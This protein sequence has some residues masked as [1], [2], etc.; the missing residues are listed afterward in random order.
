MVVLAAIPGPGIMI[1]VSR[2]LSQGFTA[3]VVTSM[4]IV[5]GDFVFIVLVVYG[6]SAMSEFL[7]G[8]FLVV[9]YAG[10]T[11]LI[12]LGLKVLLTSNSTDSSTVKNNPKHATNF[13]AGLLTTLSN[14]KAILFYVSFFPAFLD[15]STVTIMNFGAIFLVTFIA[16]GGVMVLYAFLT[17]KTGRALKASSASKYVKYGAGA[18]LIGSGLYVATRASE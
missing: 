4:G 6:L 11:Y 10:A 13:I 5:A 7:G 8:L 14:P 1:V 15:L 12:W 3:G 16:I 17:W 18:T 2:T 9:K